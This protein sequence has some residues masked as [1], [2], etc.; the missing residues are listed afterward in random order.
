MGCG[1]A[2]E[3]KDV[4]VKGRAVWRSVKARVRVA[5][6]ESE[7]NELLVGCNVVGEVAHALGC[8][9]GD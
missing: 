8:S 2:E 4:L 5:R 9:S 6:L 3:L 1:Q 7:V